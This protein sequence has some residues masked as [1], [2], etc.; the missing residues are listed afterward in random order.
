MLT[1]IAGMAIAL[2]FTVIHPAVPFAVL[3]IAFGLVMVL[4]RGL[5][6]PKYPTA[7]LIGC[8]VA[9]VILLPAVSLVKFM[10]QGLDDGP[11]YGTDYTGGV[12]GLEV[13]DRL[14][15]RRGELQIYNRQSRQA[16]VLAYQVND[17]LQWA[18]E[19]DVSQ[20]PKYRSYQLST[21]ETPTLAY[22]VIRDRVDFIG[23][24]D[25][26]TERGRVYLW[27]WGGFH[28]FY[29]SW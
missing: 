21:I 3:F 26:G 12:M 22:G 6:L 10:E 17:E 1:A 20:H 9:L 29:L 25:F 8:L 4:R 2:P 23:N 24:W 27:K 11:F 19:L 18:K 13:S 16:P 5:R 7:Y 28:R 15:Y 14:P